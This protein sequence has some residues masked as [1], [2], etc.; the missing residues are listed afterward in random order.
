MRF[1]I[2]CPGTVL[3]GLH[4]GLSWLTNIILGI[5]LQQPLVLQIAPDPASD[6]V[7]QAGAFRAQRYFDLAKVQ[8]TIGALEKHAIQKQH[9]QHK[10]GQIRMQRAAETLDE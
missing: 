3:I 9:K 5:A 2:E 7:S 1:V 4:Q 6:G 10:E 8:L